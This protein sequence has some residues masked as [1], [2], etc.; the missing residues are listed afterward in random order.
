[1][2]VKDFQPPKA[3][4]HLRLLFRK[5][6]LPALRKKAET[7][8][9]MTIIAHIDNVQFYMTQES[10]P[11]KRAADIFQAHDV[12]GMQITNCK[13]VWDAGRTVPKRNIPF[14]FRNISS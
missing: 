8:E 7:P 9:G 3:A 1:M 5:S 10:M 4:E 14:H 13:A 11:D 2:P 12:K 6:D